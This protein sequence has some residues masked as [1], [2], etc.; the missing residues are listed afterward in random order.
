MRVMIEDMAEALAVNMA[1]DL[2]EDLISEYGRRCHR[3]HE[4]G[5]PPTNDT[6]TNEHIDK[7]LI[8][9]LVG[10]LGKIKNLILY[11]LPMQLNMV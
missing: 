8:F 5:V 1:V 7:H 4:E 2:V 9:S 10:V 6:T 11:Y 3:A